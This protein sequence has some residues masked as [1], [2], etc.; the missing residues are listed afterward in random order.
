MAKA[1][2]FL[3]GFIGTFYAGYAMVWQGMIVP[4]VPSG[5]YRGIIL[6]A[7]GLVLFMVF[8][9]LAIMIAGLIGAGLATLFGGVAGK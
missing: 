4:L 2:G 1:I 5:D 8:G 3:V 7:I 6:L 9:G